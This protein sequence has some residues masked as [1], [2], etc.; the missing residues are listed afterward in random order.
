MMAIRIESG[1]TTANVVTTV[2]F[3]N[4]YGN[5]EITNRSTSDIWARVDGVNPT[6]AGAECIYVA[7]QSAVTVYNRLLPPEPALG[8]TSNTVV[9]L[10]SVANADYTV[11]GGV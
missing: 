7:S 1:T 10:I 9:K 6:I 3:A 2:T 5:I 4:W 11:S 8:F